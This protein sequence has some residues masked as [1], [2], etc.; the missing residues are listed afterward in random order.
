MHVLMDAWNTRATGTLPA[1]AGAREYG[2]LARRDY[3][4]T[5]P[6]VRPLPD[7][8]ADRYALRDAEVDATPIRSEAAKGVLDRGQ[9]WILQL[10]NLLAEFPDV[11]TDAKAAAALRAHRDKEGYVDDPAAVEEPA[12]APEP[13]PPPSAP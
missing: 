12:A 10:A 9:L 4:A 11:S 6:W 3:A 13:A 1:E 7:A 2:D 5:R 8:G